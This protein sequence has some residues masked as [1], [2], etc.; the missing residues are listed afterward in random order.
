MANMSELSQVLKTL[1]NYLKLILALT[2]LGLVSGL[3]YGI[4]SG[5]RYEALSTLYVTRQADQGNTS[6]YNYDGYYAQQ[7]S[8]EY[9]D[10]VLGLLKTID[11]YRVAAQKIGTSSDPKEIYAS[12]RS[13]KVSPQVIALSVKSQTQEEAREIMVALVSAV[14][15]SVDQVNK[16]GDNKITVSSL[17]A[18]PFITLNDSQTLIYSALGLLSGLILSL[19]YI[20]VKALLK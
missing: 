10:T 11:P 14:T 8:K 13:R 16:E 6:Y 1:R 3:V 7:A 17:Q 19:F 18:E 20:A 5:P 2:V 9:T 15:E 12:S 4:V